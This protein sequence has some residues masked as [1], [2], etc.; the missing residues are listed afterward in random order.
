[1]VKR[2]LK[3]SATEYTETSGARENVRVQKKKVKIHNM[4]VFLAHLTRNRGHI[5]SITS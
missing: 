3:R 2:I 4:N 1:M 5:T